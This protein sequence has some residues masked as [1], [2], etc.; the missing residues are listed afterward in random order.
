VNKFT[1]ERWRQIA[2]TAIAIN[3][4]YTST[5]FIAAANQATSHLHDQQLATVF[6]GVVSM[7]L[8]VWPFSIRTVGVT[9]QFQLTQWQP[10]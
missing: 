5:K 4:K 6:I 2:V 9:G 1:N 8:I 7:P 3:D 10:G